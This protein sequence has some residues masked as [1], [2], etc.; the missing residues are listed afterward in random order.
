VAL[1]H[2]RRSARWLR[3]ARLCALPLCFGALVAVSPARAQS[4]PSAEDMA[5]ARALGTEGV[6]LADLGDCAGAIPKLEAAE[7]LFHAPTTLERLGECQIKV[8]KLVAGTESLNRV[9]REPL[10]A[11]A[12]AP[13]VAAR[14]RAQDALTP[15]LPRIGKLRIHV[16][17]A[18]PDKVTVTV[19]GAAVPSVLFDSDRPT[20]PGNHEVQAVAAGYKTATSTVSLQEGGAAQVALKLE[21]DPNA[22]AAPPA[23][24]AVPAGSV[25][26]AGSTTPASPAAATSSGGGKGLAI[27]AFAVGGAGLILGATFG[28]LALSAKSK[29]DG[30][31]GSSKTAC[32][33]SAQSDINSLSTKATVSTIGFGVAIAGAATGVI[34]LL[35]SHGSEAQAPPSPAAARV[36][37]WIGFGAAGLEGSF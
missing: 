19:D 23:A 2:T 28:A 36:S 14:Q 5:S 35:T 29:L 7:K 6:R 13:F 4:T 32:P 15:A 3:H 21:P 8:G 17:G 10:P 18:P 33:A 12:P 27:G 11:N 26:P 31:C 9:A 24:G 34:L 16:D 25:T 37:P 20:D 1:L 30:E 22:I